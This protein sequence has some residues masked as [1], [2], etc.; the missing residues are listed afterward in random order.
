[1]LPTRGR[2]HE[3]DA[4]RVLATLLL[5]VFHTAMVFTAFDHFH[6]QNLQRS[7]ALGH[8]VGFIQR[9]HM[10]LFFLL[11]GMAAW[12]ALGSR[13]AREFAS[14]RVRRLFLPLLVGMLLIIPPQV[15][16]ERIST[17][18]PTR[19]S[20]I[21][22]SGNF[23]EWYPHT[24]ECCYPEANLSWH[25]L[26]FLM[27]LFVYS[28]LL[29]PLFRWLRDSGR[30]HLDRVT[31]FLGRGANLLL[32]AVWLAGAEAALRG[33]FPNNQDL[34]TDLANHA[35]YP[36]V[37]LMGFVLVS[38]PRL[39]GA[40]RRLWRWVL[41]IGVAAA[42]VPI[43]DVGYT[44]DRA[45]RGVAEWFILLGLVGLGRAALH[46]PIPWVVRFSS[47]SL[48]FYIFHQ[49]VIVVLAYWVTRWDAGIPV[50]YTVIALGAFTITWALAEAVRLT[51][52]TRAAFGLRPRR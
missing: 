42:V 22:F 33:S 21:D 29:L 34:V 52:V 43:L 36:V 28:L 6:I 17:W 5:I 20:P 25:H 41:P 51:P 23:F 16:V 2:R 31:G 49:T 27:Y 7:E 44:A 50:K 47:I 48:P 32:P 10:P 1:M 46:R 12:F 8:L 39:D 38:D 18:V 11:A 30:E 14:E 19:Q 40:L 37:F 35:N 45:L 15:Y 24:F 3:I 26:W 4:L 13:T 9:W